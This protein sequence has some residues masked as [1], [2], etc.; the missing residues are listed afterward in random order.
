MSLGFHPFLYTVLY[1]YNLTLPVTESKLTHQLHQARLVGQLLRRQAN[2]Q[3]GEKTIAK[4]PVEGRDIHD[5]KSGLLMALDNA[6]RI[7]TVGR[8]GESANMF[9]NDDKVRPI[10]LNSSIFNFRLF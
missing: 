5:F 3:P 7:G 8:I 9:S 10:L 2:L 4:V 6:S 1:T